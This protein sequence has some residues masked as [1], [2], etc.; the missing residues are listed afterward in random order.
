MA[1][2]G[3]AGLGALGVAIPEPITTIIGAG[4]LGYTALQAL[5]LGQG[6]GLFNNNLLGGDT[7]VVG[8]VTLG[9]P[10]LPEPAAQ[11]LEKE[12]HVKYDWGTLQYYMVKVPGQPRKILL[13]NTK[14]QL[15]K[16]WTWRKPSLAVIGKNMPSHKM[17]VRLR[18]NLGKQSA[19]A[20]SVLRLVS[21][22]S[23]AVHHK[24]TR[25]R[26]VYKRPRWHR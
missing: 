3:L 5:G 15:W 14:T 12:W 4:L 17:L 22:G 11:Y 21:P 16:Y 1:T 25:T 8:G 6:G 10:G 26:V 13:Y 19:D 2:L 7:A 23:L 24:R 9:G 20:K 18:R